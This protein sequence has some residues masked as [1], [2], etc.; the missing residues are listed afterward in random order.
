MRRTQ[1]QRAEETTGELVA[2]AGELFGRDG[3][4]AT[5]LDD[6]A[7][8]AG[9]TK[10]AV[11]HHFGGKTPLFRAALVR[12]QQ[13]LAERLRAVAVD[14]PWESV[15]RG[16]AEFLS[17]CLDPA[18]RQI[19]LLDGPAVLGWAE[20]REIED[21]YVTALLRV[22]LQRAAAAEAA[23]ADASAGVSGGAV[24]GVAGGGVSA[25][26]SG[27]AVAGVAG[28]G[29][30]A[31]VSGGAV[32]A[33]AFVGA[34]GGVEARLHVLRGA[35]CEAGMLLARDPAVLPALTREIDILVDA[36]RAVAGGG[37]TAIV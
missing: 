4:A 28:G 32:D 25:G 2:R 3:Y 13:M 6:V 18:V 11:Y 29:A 19:L 14:D 34:V 16:C 27:G 33:G 1:A 15:R 12:R 26:V 23:A 36:Y 31:R 30:S 24:A 37:V 20:L 21:Q 17:A 8:A 22:G 35:L 9:L 5:S 10:G 7:R